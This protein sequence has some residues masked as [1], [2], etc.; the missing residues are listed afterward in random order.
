M[1][2]IITAVHPVLAARDVADSARF[3]SQL[4]FTTTFMDDPAAPRYAGVV[5]GPVELHLQWGDPSQWEHAGDRPAI[6]FVV[7]DV[8][9]LFAEFQAAGVFTPSSSGGPWAKPGNTPWGTREFHLRDPG[10]NVLQFYQPL[11]MS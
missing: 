6:R 7:P 10:G 9:A 3:Y 1:P 5:R 11:P 8:D 4:G 2:A